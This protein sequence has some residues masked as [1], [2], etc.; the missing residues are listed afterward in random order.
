MKQMDRKVTKVGKWEGMKV[1]R[2]EGRWE[3]MKVGR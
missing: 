1:G 2:K 3:G